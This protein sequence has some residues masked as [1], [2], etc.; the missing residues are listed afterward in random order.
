[1]SYP[2][3]WMASDDPKDETGTA[4]FMIDGV[5]YVLRLDSFLAFQDVSKMLDATFKQGKVFAAR[6]MRSHI[7]KSLDIAEKQHD[8]S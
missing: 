5:K 4:T 1:M 6:A 8:L 2:C 3:E 7:E